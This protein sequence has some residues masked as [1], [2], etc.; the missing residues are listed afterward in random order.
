MDIALVPTI[1]RGRF[2]LE[3]LVALLSQSHLG[4]Q[5]ME[6]LYLRSDRGDWLD[7]RAKLVRPA[8]IQAIGQHWSHSGIKVNRLTSSAPRTEG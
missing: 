3:K 5:P 7:Q 1:A 4:D 6:G 8:F 2:T